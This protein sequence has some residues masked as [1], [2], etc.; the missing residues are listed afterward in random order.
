MCI[1]YGGPHSK[2]YLN[3][4]EAYST[5]NF[6]FDSLCT[7]LENLKLLKLFTLQNVK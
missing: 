1:I 3:K 7:L 4:N 2:K 6:V 5:V